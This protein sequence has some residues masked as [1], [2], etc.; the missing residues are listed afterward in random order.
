MGLEVK[1]IKIKITE[2]GNAEI[3]VNGIKGSSCEEITSQLIQ[4]LG[5]AEETQYTEEYDAELPDYVE[6]M[7]D[8]NE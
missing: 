4:S 6:A 3:E 7:T 2:D 1:M 8:E 5:E